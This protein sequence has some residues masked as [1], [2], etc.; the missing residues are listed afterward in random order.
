MSRATDYGSQNNPNEH[1]GSLILEIRSIV[2][3]DTL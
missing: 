1:L 2:S 3:C